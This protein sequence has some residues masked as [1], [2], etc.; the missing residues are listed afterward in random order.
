ML[1]LEKN[2]AYSLH[3]VGQEL[4]DLL[5]FNR[6]LFG[7]LLNKMIHKPCYVRELKKKLFNLVSKIERHVIYRLRNTHDG[8][9]SLAL[10]DMKL[11]KNQIEEIR[12]IIIKEKKKLKF[13]K[14]TLTPYLHWLDITH[15]KICLYEEIK[16]EITTVDTDCT[17][18]L[19]AIDSLG[20]Q[21]NKTRA[22]ILP[23]WQ[24]LYEKFFPDFYY[25]TFKSNLEKI[26]AIKPST[27]LPSLYTLLLKKELLHKALH[28]YRDTSFED[29]P[30]LFINI[31]MTMATL[32]E[33]EREIKTSRN[34]INNFLER[35]RERLKVISVDEAL[36]HVGQFYQIANEN[37]EL[38]RTFEK[39]SSLS[40]TNFARYT[41]HN[42]DS[43]KEEASKKSKKSFFKF[44]FPKLFG[45][46]K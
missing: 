25:N 23:L 18:F 8:N 22:L 35:V 38:T 10:N 45:S 40:M 3:R 17:Q 19:S 6:T 11:L 37:L 33:I 9:M 41:G 26:S 28:P 34:P 24:T 12:K 43:E 4:F 1:E 31:D 16:K 44:K 42:K 30:E 29:R 2:F 39:K 7:V 13:F 5:E 46:R 15:E 32:G 20:A 14:F 21:H 27:E 36:E